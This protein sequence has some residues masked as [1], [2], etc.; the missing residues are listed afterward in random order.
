M[1]TSLRLGVVI[2]LL[3]V[4]AWGCSSQR[5]S[6]RRVDS[7]FSNASAPSRL[8]VQINN[9]TDDDKSRRNHVELAVNGKKLKPSRA[10]N[11]CLFELTLPSGTHKIEAKYRAKSFW[12]DK[13]FKLATHD[14]RVRLYPGYT[15]FLTM[16]LEKRSDGSLARARN[17]FTEAPRAM[18]K[19]AAP[20]IAQATQPERK[21][22]EAVRVA[23]LEI[24]QESPSTNAAEQERPITVVPVAPQTASVTLISA[25]AASIDQ[26]SPPEPATPIVTLDRVATSTMPTEAKPA[27]TAPISTTPSI[28]SVQVEQRPTPIEAPPQTNSAIISHPET[29]ALAAGKIALQINTS[30][31]G[32]EVIVDD[33][34]LG[35]S[36][37]VTYVERGRSHVIQISRKG[38]TEKIKLLDRSAFG[39]QQTYFLIE[40]MEKEE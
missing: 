35:Q 40:K 22:V 1:K 11:D 13:D 14:G 39:N 30:P 29:A 36:P 12:K 17:F 3:A 4:L 38:Y 5:A 6:S 16:T 24:K 7:S 9:V 25:P 31:A 33:K 23:P 15:T 10:A 28:S 2:V 34:Y 32:A 26:T 21:I 8:V 20:R 18:A 19:P 37:L 27:N